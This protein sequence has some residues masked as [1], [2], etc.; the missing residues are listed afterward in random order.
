MTRRTQRERTDSTRTAL[1]DATLDLL[2]EVGWAATTSVAV[3]DRAGLTRGALVHHF[4]DLPNL[5]AESLD[6]HYAR[7]AEQA[8]VDDLPS[9]MAE[10]TR[11]TWATIDQGRFKIVIEAWLAAANDPQLGQAL[12]PVIARF[13]KL[14]DVDATG[15]GHDESTEALFLTI[16]ETM[17]GLALGRATAGGPLPHEHLVVDHLI[18]LAHDDDSRTGGTR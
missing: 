2:D 8:H 15:L 9:T 1:I 6:A 11:L 12:A 4:G 17:L 5:L 18:S 10:V 13:A 16:R 14:V 7:L 3:C